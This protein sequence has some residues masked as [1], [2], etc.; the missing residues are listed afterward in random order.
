MSL[1]MA[2]QTRQWLQQKISLGSMKEKII[3][4]TADPIESPKTLKP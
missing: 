1:R 4:K 2:D 3:V